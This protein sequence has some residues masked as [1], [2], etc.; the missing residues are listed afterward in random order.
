M[1]TTG[2]YFWGCQYPKIANRVPKFKKSGNGKPVDQKIPGT[3]KSGARN[4][5]KSG[6][7][8]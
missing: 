6:Q 1:Y 8:L 4:F 5:R 3:E 7:I 2:K